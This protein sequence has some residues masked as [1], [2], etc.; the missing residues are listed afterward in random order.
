MKV[1]RRM[2]I[3]AVLPIALALATGLI[4]GWMTVNVKD[5]VLRLRA[6][7]A[8]TRDVF[9][10]DMITHEYAR[11]P[12]PESRT[13]WMTIHARISETV[14]RET[15]TSPGDRA[16]FEDISRALE[17]SK[18][19]FA[20]LSAQMARG[21]SSQSQSVLTLQGRLRLN[22]QAMVDEALFLASKAHD[23]TIAI[24]MASFFMIIGTCSVLAIILTIIAI[25]VSRR[26]ES[27]LDALGDGTLRVARGQLGHQIQL[28]GGDELGELA[29]AFNAM[30]SALKKDQDTIRAEMAERQKIA[31]SLATSNVQL[32]DALTRLKRAQEEVI[33]QE[34]LKVLKQMADGI[35]HD[36]YDAM[37]PV[38]GYS[39]LLLRFPGEINTPSGREQI[40]AIHDAVTKTISVAKHLS[41]YF[42]PTRQHNI[43]PVNLPALVENVLARILPA[44]K[45]Q[46]RRI[47]VKTDL[48]DL[49]AFNSI[50]ADI[51]EALVNVITNA[52]EA[53]DKSGTL[54]IRARTDRQDIVI[55]VSDTG[56]GMSAVTR[57]R[58]LEPFYS[59]K[60]QGHS[61]MGLTITRGA[62]ARC[63][64]ELSIESEPDRGTTVTIRIPDMPPTGAAAGA[65]AMTP[66][67]GRKL[68]ILVVDDEE[69][70]RKLLA[71]ALKSMGCEVETAS[72]GKAAV[73]MFL[74]GSFDVAIVDMAMPGMSGS[75]LAAEFK[76]I[77]PA[78]PVI[79]LTGF[80]DIL[81]ES[82]S[83]PE[84]VD[85][86]LSKPMPLDELQ[87]AIYRVTEKPAG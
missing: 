45:D 84:G 82:G 2:Q 53:M 58:C 48:A 52:A 67:Q 38:L 47:A 12:K 85:F 71:Q 51:N 83:K 64:G 65:P 22:T 76:K 13:R 69:C 72:E 78:I 43:T 4:L 75:E 55:E 56:A 37:M 15:A 73:E 62:I 25:L 34:R 41:E 35:L 19:V 74:P 23:Q 49:P 17:R 31:D 80:G 77:R 7:N 54:T 5:I 3:V 6:A 28:Q 26:I 8:V 18:T 11:A 63:Q 9:L 21:A 60:G 32:S 33:Q 68:R 66:H 24:Q 61:G 16:I 39:E 20:D 14:A 86:I 30:S 1:K 79:M 87:N 50:E 29:E 10:L 46:G 42:Y 57:R 36:I 59:T 40:Q 81:K 44:W 27:G 70:I